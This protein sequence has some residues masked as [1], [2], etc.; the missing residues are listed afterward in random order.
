MLVYAWTRLITYLTSPHLTSP[1]LTLPYLTLPYLISSY[2]II[3][4][5]L[6]YLNLFS[7]ILHLHGPPWGRNKS[8][9]CDD[10]LPG[11][12]ILSPGNEFLTARTIQIQPTIFQ[13]F[14]LARW[15]G[16][17]SA[18]RWISINERPPYTICVPA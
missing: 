9:P 10:S 15:R 13:V 8:C 2:L 4:Y 18:A 5:S 11:R 12:R 6:S 7:L 17:S 14:C 16:C 3:F 1:H